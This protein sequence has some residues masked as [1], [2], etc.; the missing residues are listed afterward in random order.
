MT[1]PLLQII[2]EQKKDFFNSYI[3]TNG[4][5]TTFNWHTSSIK[6]LLQAQVEMLEKIKRDDS[7]TLGRMAYGASNDVIQTQINLLQETINSMKRY[8]L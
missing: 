7:D 5:N 8:E 3:Y 2:E 1:N 4:E 6:A